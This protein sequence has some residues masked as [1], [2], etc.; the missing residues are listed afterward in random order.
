MNLKKRGTVGMRRSARP[1]A[2][3]RSSQPLRRLPVPVRNESTS[4]PRIGHQ[5]R[6]R[7]RELNLTLE[8]LAEAVCLT[9]G[10]LSDIENEKA[11]PS[12]A[13]LLQLCSALNLSV[14]SLFTPVRSAVVRAAE[15][16]QIKFYGVRLKDFLL[17]APSA[18]RLLVLWTEVQPG[19][20]GGP[21][22]Y[23]MPCDENFVLVLSGSVIFTFDNDE[24]HVL[25]AGD[26][27][28]YSARR[29]H[30]FANP[31]TDEAATV[32]FVM[33]PPPN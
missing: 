19:G 24:Q 25:N 33:T 22:S 10:F 17:T 7:R 15:R 31:S 11:S 6:A 2:M 16:P 13:S 28:T 32:L 30:N 5:L 20:R 4:S 18:S 8:A 23:S 12:I 9:K 14:G 26:A 1:A 29:P 27:L 3:P 21:Q